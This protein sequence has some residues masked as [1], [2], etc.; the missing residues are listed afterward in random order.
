MGWFLMATA[1][2]VLVSV[3]F[4]LRAKEQT[5]RDVLGFLLFAAGIFTAGAAQSFLAGAAERRFTLVGVVA[6][7]LGLI[8]SRLSDRRTAP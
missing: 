3:V 5:L 1:V 8:L 6:V 4:Q 2:V 7:F